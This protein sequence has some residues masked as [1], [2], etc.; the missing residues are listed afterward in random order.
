[1]DMDQQDLKEFIAFRCN[2]PLEGGRVCDKVVCE[3]WATSCSHIFCQEHAREWFQEHDFCPVCRDEKAGKVRVLQIGGAPDP[4]LGP[5]SLLIGRLPQEGVTALKTAF[6]FWMEQKF[7]RFQE[8]LAREEEEKE[9]VERV[10]SNGRKRLVEVQAK[11]TIGGKCFEEV[12]HQHRA[13]EKELAEFREEVQRI[14]SRRVKVR[15]AYEGLLGSATG[16][17]LG[18]SGSD[19]VGFA[20]RSSP[21]R[22]ASPQ[23]SAA[24]SARLSPRGPPSGGRRMLNSLPSYSG[25]RS[26]AH[27]IRRGTPSPLGSSRTLRPALALSPPPARSSRGSRS[28]RRPAERRGDLW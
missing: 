22:R 5:E 17:T 14:D 3:A 27:S 20:P 18:S 10:M 28:P 8:S 26:A 23:Q 4:K 9:K 7:H 1:M 13:A 15:R 11:Y 21:G 6:S 24:G 12:A 25:L 2:M 16:V 19:L